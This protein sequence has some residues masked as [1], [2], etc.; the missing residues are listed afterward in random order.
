MFGI[1]DWVQAGERIVEL[2]FPQEG[3]EFQHAHRGAVGHVLNLTDDPEW[4]NV[5]WEHSGAP[6]VC[7]VDELIW[8]CKGDA[9]SQRE[10]MRELQK[11]K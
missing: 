7:H 6:C 10:I 9:F 2:D 11:K 8:L 3:L 4:V 1:A 5:F